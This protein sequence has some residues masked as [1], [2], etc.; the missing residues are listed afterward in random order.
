[1]AKCL[2]TLITG[3]LLCVASLAIADNPR[4]KFVTTDGDMVVELFEKEA[5]KT[6]ANFLFYVNEGRYNHTLFHRVIEGFV[7]QGGGYQDGMKEIDTE[8]P[9]DLETSE[10]IKNKR[11]TIAM[12]RH[13]KPKS[14]TSQFFFNLSDNQNLDKTAIK[15]GYAVFG[16]I[17]EG[18][19]TVDYIS[20]VE[21]IN[22]DDWQ[23]I[24]K[25]PV[26]LIKA[27]VIEE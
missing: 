16:K 14:A 2:K 19:E 15:D 3:W 6:V 17:V 21:T 4:V 10:T 25:F 1:M 24:P 11:G 23:D 13:S 8:D 22:T 20:I 27:E 5:P 18:L 26:I 9:I 12:A 7:V